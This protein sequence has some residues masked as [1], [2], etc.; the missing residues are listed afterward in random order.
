MG[1][2]PGPAAQLL[3]IRSALCEFMQPRLPVDVVRESVVD[4]AAAIVSKRGTGDCD[5]SRQDPILGSYPILGHAPK[6][7][8]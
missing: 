4:M 1:A 2:A 3:P 5:Y 8:V 7:T 6:D